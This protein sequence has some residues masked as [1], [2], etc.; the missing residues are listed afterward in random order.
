MSQRPSLRQVRL[1]CGLTQAALAAKVGISRQAVAAIE[2]GSYEPSLA[3]AMRVARV[4]GVAVEELF[5]P[6]DEMTL[7]I[8]VVGSHQ[9]GDSVELLEVEG[10][11]RA[12]PKSGDA[13]L[14]TGFRTG[15]GVVVGLES[16]G[17]L[18]EST[19]PVE[20]GVIVAGCDPVLGTLATLASERGVRASWLEATNATAAT[21][22]K[23]RVA[24]IVGVHVREGEE[25]R[26]EELLSGLGECTFYE[27]AHWREGLVTARDREAKSM[28]Q[29]SRAPLRVANRPI[30]SEARR[31]GE[32]AVG[33]LGLPRDA[34]IGW[35]SALSGHIAVAATVAGG[36]ADFGVTIE[37][38]SI[39]FHLNFE[40]LTKE[41]S[42]LVVPSRVRDLPEVTR[43][44][45]TLSSKEFQTR[46]GRLPG[47]GISSPL[48]HEVLRP[49]S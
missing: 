1:G 13:S 14:G 29:G 25:R 21:L 8:P 40:P 12:L 46:L 11:V 39:D 30:G 19:H 41:V 44:V 20:S 28:V 33:W 38:A 9:V 35:D 23:E 32:E 16:E 49:H 7:A 15:S 48:R 22:G 5:A 17:V 42:Y 37:P 45:G 31:V 24:Q 47:Y 26:L 34:L 18:V 43:L 6:L 4:V 3:V 27:V 2:A 10:V 36:A